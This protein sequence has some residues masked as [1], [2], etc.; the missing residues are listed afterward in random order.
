MR[1]V[2]SWIKNKIIDYYDQISN[3]VSAILSIILSLLANYI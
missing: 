3:I 2:F 1:K